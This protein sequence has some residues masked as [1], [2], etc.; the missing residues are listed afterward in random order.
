MRLRGTSLT[1]VQSPQR[2]ALLPTVVFEM[3]T[4][5]CFL[6]RA[7]LHPTSRGPA[8][9]LGADYVLFQAPGMECY[10]QKGISLIVKIP[11]KDGESSGCK[12]NAY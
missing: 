6:L 1:A 4:D 5:T 11:E 2:P 12:R 8:L 7:P 10:A 3:L 9:S